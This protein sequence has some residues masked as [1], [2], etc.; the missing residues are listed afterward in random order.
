MR[1]S[2]T[3]SEIMIA[4]IFIA[5][6]LSGIL[7]LFI[8]CML[9]NAANRNSTVAITHAQ[10][11]MEEVRGTDFTLIQGLVGGGHWDLDSTGLSAAPYNLAVLDNEAIDTTVTV[12]GN[13]LEI[14]VVVSW[15][16][17]LGRNRNEQLLTRIADYQ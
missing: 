2:L 8:N 14:E 6:A 13:M 16:D 9:L 3:L 10:Y 7:L 11:I 1:K 4:T 5:V 15:Q 17:R 12:V